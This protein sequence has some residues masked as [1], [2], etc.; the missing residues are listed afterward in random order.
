MSYEG[1]ALKLIISTDDDT[2]FHYPAGSYENLKLMTDNFSHW[3][4]DITILLTVSHAVEIVLETKEP[5][6]NG[7][8][9]V[10]FTDMDKWLSHKPIAYGILVGS[11]MHST[12][13]TSKDLSSYLG[14]LLLLMPG[15]T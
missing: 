5:P 6:Q 13:H 2:Y 12:M 14:S 10:A 3:K 4:T 8:T 11:C 15:S 1:S 9:V 7:N